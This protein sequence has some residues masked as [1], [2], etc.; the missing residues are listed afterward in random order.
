MVVTGVMAAPF[1]GCRKVFCATTAVLILGSSLPAAGETI[2]D[3]V[4]YALQNNNARKAAIEAIEAQG[5]QVAI[6]QGERR[7]TVQLFGEVAAERVDDPTSRFAGESDDFKLAREISL[8]VEYPLLDGMRSLNS[9]YREAT[10]LD[11][12]IIRLSDEMETLAL[13][14]VQA[15]VNVVRHRDVLRLARTNVAV[16]ERIR[17][18]VAQQVEAGK[19]PGS[20]LFRAEDKLLEA[21]LARSEAESSLADSI[22]SYQFLMG[23]SPTGAMSLSEAPKIPGSSASLERNAVANSFRLKSSQKEIDALTYQER[24]DDADWQPQLDFFAGARLGQDLDGTSGSE[25]TLQAG[26]RLNWTLHK[27]GTR[28][29]TIARNRDLIMR[30][31]YRRKQLEGEVRDFARRAWISYATALERRGLLDTAV[32]TS[33]QLAEA[34]RGEFEAAK[35]PLLQVLEAERDLF[36]LRVRRVNADAAV[37]FQRYRVLAA[38]NTLA[39][40]FGLAHAGHALTAN[41]EDRAKSDP[42]KPFVVSTS[43]AE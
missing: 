7:S 21:R 42:R 16:H 10:L 29:A 25:S 35:R 4:R 40:H 15:Y 2:R 9:V 6:A 43:P 30:A 37:A 24:I 11:A 1:R 22:S 36:N 12:E 17:A 32:E 20:D 38:Q 13:N 34:Y 39:G 5:N 26:V 27:G 18:Q 31:H 23:R 8:G 41:Y 3:A 14:A 19:L 28:S 33:A